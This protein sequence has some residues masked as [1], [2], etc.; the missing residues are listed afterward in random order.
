MLKSSKAKVGAQMARV[1][2][3]RLVHRF[4]VGRNNLCMIVYS[5]I[6]A[7]LKMEF[8]EVNRELGSRRMIPSSGLIRFAIKI[9]A[10]VKECVVRGYRNVKG[11]A[12]WTL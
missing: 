8:V 12:L 2:H 10:A 3:A 5:G 1:L 9:S 7:T 11:G 6:I 4:V